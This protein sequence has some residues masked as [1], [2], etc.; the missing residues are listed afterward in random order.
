L[1]W[2]RTAM[3]ILVQCSHGGFWVFRVR[4]RGLVHDD[5]S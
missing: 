4:V 3:P 1:R 2:F 5:L